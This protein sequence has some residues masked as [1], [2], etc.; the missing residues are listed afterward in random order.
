MKKIQ[1][2]M[3]MKKISMLLLLLSAAVFKT[4]ARDGYKIRLKL[5]DAKD[6]TVYM[7]HYYAKPLP[8]I[9]KADSAKLDKNG[10]AVFDHKDKMLGGIYMI[11]VPY[12]KAYFEFLL[13]NGDD[14]SITAA[15]GS[16]PQNLEVKNSPENDHFLAYDKYMRTYGLEQQKYSE[17]IKTA[18][19]SAD[20][21]SIKEKAGKSFKAMT[22]YR[23]NLAATYPGSLLGA[24]L[25]AME[26]PAVPEKKHYLENG[27]VD[28][29]YDYVYYKDHYWDKFDL[30][31]DRLIHTPIYEGKLDDFFNKVVM[32]MP[33]SIE[34]ESD[35]L[36]A[37]ARGTNEIFKYTLSWLSDFAQNSKVMGMDEVFVYLVENYFMKGDATW[38]SHEDLQKYEKR[39]RDIAPNVIGNVAPDIQMID[40]NKQ[41]HKLYDVKAKYTLLLFWSPDCGHCQHEVPLLDSL[42]KAALKQ[43]DVKVFAVRTEGDEK[44]WQ[45]FI[46][47]HKLEEWTHVYDPEY[48]SNYKAD[49]DVYMTPIIYL[50]D[51]KKIIRGKKIDHSNILDV[52]HMLEAREKT[53][54]KN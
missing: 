51:N 4:E 43:K 10:V 5:T 3:S 35:A 19:T 7:A 50:L 20:S 39:A 12:K 45:D 36:L 25:N 9:Y 32:Q 13:N 48:H 44:K 29:M 30:H 42:Y 16:T 14:I 26:L 23:K 21:A 37:K 8:T 49:Y 1:A 53:S 47:E 31:D 2:S 33:D 11:W 27:R 18:K 40:I 46:K 54:S 22:E 24:I 41:P 38:L 15:I 52:I 17:D 34:K 28:S 6:S